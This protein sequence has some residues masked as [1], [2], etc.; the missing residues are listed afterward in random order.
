MLSID[1]LRR[2]IANTVDQSDVTGFRV[3][4]KLPP[5][6]KLIAGMRPD[7]KIFDPENLVGRILIRNWWELV[8]YREYPNFD[9]ILKP[10]EIKAL[11]KFPQSDLLDAQWAGLSVAFSRVRTNVIDLLY[12]FTDLNKQFLISKDIVDGALPLPLMLIWR[13]RLDLQEGYDVSQPAGRIGFLQ[14]WF[15][16]GHDEYVRP[17]WTLATDWLDFA[18]DEISVPLPNVLSLLIANRE[19]LHKNLPI[20]TEEGRLAALFWWEQQGFNECSVPSWS[21]MW[22]TPLRRIL[23]ARASNFDTEALPEDKRPAITLPYLLLMIRR[24]RQDLI[25]AFD[26]KIVAGCEDLLVWWEMHGKTE[27]KILIQLFQNPDS[28]VSGLNIVG[29][30]QSVIG[31]AE[32]VRMAAKSASLADLGYCVIDTPMPGPEKSEHSLDAYLVAAPIYPLSLYCL[33]PQEIFRL[34]MSGRPR[35]LN[36]GAYNIGGWHWELPSWPESLTKVTNLVDEIWVYTDFV[37]DTFAKISAKPILKMPLAVEIYPYEAC[38]RP[39]FNFPE[40]SFLFLSMFDGNSW[41]TRKNPIAAVKAFKKAFKDNRHVGFVMKAIGLDKSS[42]GWQE[43]EME[44]NGDPRFIVVDNALSRSELTQMMVLCD[45][46]VSL[47]RSEGFGRI[48]AEAM[49]LNIPTITT[50]FSG[51]TEFCTADTSYLVNGPLISLK[52]DDYL[53]SEGNFW[54][55]PDVDEAAEQMRRLFEDTQHRNLV[56]TSAYN[57]IQTNYS[58][59]TAGAAYRS[60]LI[61]LR[62]MG[63]I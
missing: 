37:H 44:I 10:Y 26:I 14:W 1:K 49:L 16:Q 45:A 42:V 54:C 60:R 12:R 29:Y 59:K 50:N 32:D 6:I 55:D 13:D 39:N 3:V 58:A 53:F 33:P 31:I 30:A 19:D 15:R 5:E 63:A 47:H 46:Y 52:K 61:E 41:L 20:C 21:F 35:L 25:E 38:G 7:L 48:I 22:H 27:Y 62:E 43:I 56:L 24:L 9:W 4:L 2:L 34:E 8:G 28:E 18:P 36:S 23:S 17:G 51:N 57:N 11:Q 40:H